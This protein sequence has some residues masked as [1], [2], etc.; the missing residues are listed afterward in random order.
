MFSKK[1]YKLLPKEEVKTP[2]GKVHSVHR[3]QAL[4]DIPLHGVK[5]GDFGGYVWGRKALSHEGSCWVGGKAMALVKDYR[6]NVTGDA[7]VTDNAIV[8]GSFTDEVRISGKANVNGNFNG[9]CDISGNVSI[10]HGYFDGK[11]MIK[12]NVHIVQAHISA[13]GGSQVALSGD[14]FIDCPLRDKK[15]ITDWQKSEFFIYLMDSEVIE[16]SGNVSLENAFIRG[17]CKMNGIFSL[18]NVSFKGDN[19]ILG[20]PDIKPD[21]KFSGTNEIT[22]NS[23]IPPGS[24]VHGVVMSSGVLDYS[25][26]KLVIPNIENSKEH[27]STPEVNQENSKYISFIDQIEAEYEAYTTDIVKLIKYPA[28]VD[29]SIPEIGEFLVMLRFVKR[30]AKIVNESELKEMV[31]DLDMAFVHA[32]NKARTLVASHLDESNKKSLKNAE[33]M[34]NIAFDE[35]APDPEKKMGFKAGMRALEGVIDVSDQAV[36]NIKTRIGILELES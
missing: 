13:Y 35:A 12:D 3:I 32:E 14:V 20:S 6:S 17:S 28:M 34:F 18:E 27:A 2:D 5:A 26:P 8:Y 15:T 1:K 30:S 7:L 10:G 29:S 22:G 4:V 11:V 33:R 19:T 31:A 36:E 23:F 25:A 24:H 16:I 9:S 21:T